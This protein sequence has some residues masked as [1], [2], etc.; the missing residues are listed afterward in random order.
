MKRIGKWLIPAVLALSFLW[1]IRLV[2][3]GQQ[4]QGRLRLEEALRRGVVACYASEGFYPPDLDYLC[5]NYGVVYDETRYTIEYAAV[6]ANL[7]PD[8]TVL[9]K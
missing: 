5:R 4:H 7:M 8:I 9:E 2:E 6:G 1:G 3:Q